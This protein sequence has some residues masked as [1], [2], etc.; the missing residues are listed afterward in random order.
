MNYGRFV[1]SYLPWGQASTVG[2]AMRRALLGEI[3][4]TSITCARFHGI[5]HEYSTVTGIKKAIHDVLV[6]LKEV[7]LRG[8][9]ND[10]KEA[11]NRSQRNNCG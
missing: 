10:V 3:R 11:R 2:V 1:L 9:S 5:V 8:D 7:A 4:G 6:N